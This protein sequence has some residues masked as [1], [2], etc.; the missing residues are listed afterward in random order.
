MAKLCLTAAS[1]SVMLW[2]VC[3]AAVAWRKPQN[4]LA[5]KPTSWVSSVRGCCVCATGYVYSP[6]VELFWYSVYTAIVDVNTALQQTETQNNLQS[7]WASVQ[8]H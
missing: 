2:F 5:G 8:G 1:N 7:G 4:F 6:K 3:K